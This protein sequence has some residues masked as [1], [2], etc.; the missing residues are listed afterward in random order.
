MPL[1]LDKS[2][3]LLTV[4]ELTDLKEDSPDLYG[5]IVDGKSVKIFKESI[6]HSEKKRTDEL[7]IFLNSTVTEHELSPLHVAVLSGRVEWI[8]FLIEIGADPEKKDRYGWT[9][10]H[11]CAFFLNLKIL[12]YLKNLNRDFKR[13][14]SGL[15]CASISDICKNAVDGLSLSHS[16]YKSLW[17]NSLINQTFSNPTENPSL[18]EIED[19]KKICLIELLIPRS[20]PEKEQLIKDLKSNHSVLDRFNN[21]NEKNRSLSQILYILSHP[22]I[23]I[24]LHL[25]KIKT[26]ATWLD[27]FSKKS[28]IMKRFFDLVSRDLFYYTIGLCHYLEKMDQSINHLNKENQEKIIKLIISRLEKFS[29][30]EIFTAIDYLISLNQTEI[31]EC[32]EQ[33]FSCEQLEEF[34]KELSWEF[35]NTSKTFGTSFVKAKELYQTEDEIKDYLTQYFYSRP[36]YS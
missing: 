15:S 35:F 32:Y 1:K 26:G 34:K 28:I 16:L 8:S 27:L 29:M 30:K 17:S 9:A 4:Y 7:S 33:L 24:F 12:P 10:Y 5:A 2:C 23:I 19:Y 3:Q 31:K 6:F 11:H 36:C 22:N 14:S 13:T 18:S 20:I 21:E 25:E